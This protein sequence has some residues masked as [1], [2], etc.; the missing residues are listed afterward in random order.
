MKR[1]RRRRRRRGGEGGEEGDEKE[2]IQNL[3]GDISYKACARY[4]LQMYH[5]LVNT[6]RDEMLT[7]YDAAFY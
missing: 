4:D 1:R 2:E 3:V 5:S 6:K 7:F